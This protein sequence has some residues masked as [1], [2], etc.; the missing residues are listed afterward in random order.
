MQFCIPVGGD[1]LKKSQR[2][3]IDFDMKKITLTSVGSFHVE[4]VGKPW[5]VF[6][7]RDDIKWLLS[8]WKKVTSVPPE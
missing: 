3:I 7:Q 1:F 4:W 5:E 8:V 2:D 6:E